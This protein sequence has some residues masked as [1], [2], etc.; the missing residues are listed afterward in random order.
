M[1]T[2]QSTNLAATTYDAETQTLTIDFVS[3]AQYDYYEVPEYI[4]DELVQ[5]IDPNSYFKSAIEGK[6]TYERVG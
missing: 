1:P 5:A 2:L 3:G 4:Y 6:F